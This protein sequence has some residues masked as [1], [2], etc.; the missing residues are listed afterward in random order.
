[1]VGKSKNRRGAA[2]IFYNFLCAFD[3]SKHT[4]SMN[5]DRNAAFL[6]ITN[7]KCS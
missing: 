6:Q 4:A 2:E 1:M 3:N 5:I 7:E